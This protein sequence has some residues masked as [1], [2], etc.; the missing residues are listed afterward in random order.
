M[1]SV[2][3]MNDQPIRLGTRASPLAFVQARTVQKVLENQGYKV[4]LYP[5]TTSGDRLK[6]RPLEPYGGKVLF[7]KEIEEALAA[8]II[9]LAVHSVKDI[10]LTNPYGLIL[11]GVLERE[12]CRDVFISKNVSSFMALPYGA[13]IGTASPRRT[14]QALHKRPDLKLTLLRGNVET[15]LRKVE[16]GLY[17]GTFLAAAG[18]VRLG[19]STHITEFLPCEEWVPAVG[20]GAIGLQYHPDHPFMGALISQISHKTSLHAIKIERAFLKGFGG[21]CTTPVGG[22]FNG[23]HLHVWTACEPA[24]KAIQEKITL[25]G[26]A[27]QEACDAA[28]NFGIEFARQRFIPLEYQRSG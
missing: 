5:F 8:K 26:L 25:K 23:S 9:D 16:E 1:N 4:D 24:P 2:D 12:D 21:S 13:M 7:T 14:A 15:R 11:G 3:H 6:D 18:L 27:F 22:Y 19:L 10:E 20:Q 17:D 28:Y